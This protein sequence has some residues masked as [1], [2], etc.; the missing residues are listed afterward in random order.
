[1]KFQNLLFHY[2]KKR[3]PYDNEG[4]EAKHHLQGDIIIFIK[5]VEDNIL[6]LKIKNQSDI[7]T[8]RTV[9]ISELYNNDIIKIPYFNNK[10]KIQII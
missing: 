10:F 2:T 1:M 3:N 6:N 5:V 7:Y 4:H 8:N 9:T